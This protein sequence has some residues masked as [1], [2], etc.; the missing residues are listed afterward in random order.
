MHSVS[1]ERP[2]LLD[3]GASGSV[4]LYCAPHVPNEVAE[5]LSRWQADEELLRNAQWIWERHYLVVLRIV[6]IGDAPPLTDDET[7]RVGGLAAE[8]PDDVSTAIL[9]LLLNA[10]VLSEDRAVLRAVYGDTAD[11]EERAQWLR[12][13]LAGRALGE[14]DFIVGGGVTLANALTSVTVISVSE[15]VKAL[16][17]MP[18][19]GL[20]AAALAFGFAVARSKESISNRLQILGQAIVRIA[21]E[22]QPVLQ[23]WQLDRA[24]AA[25]HLLSATPSPAPLTGVQNWHHM[26][27]G[28]LTRACVEVLARVGPMSARQLA[29]RL[30]SLPVAQG[31]AK[32]RAS[33]RN[34]SYFH[35]LPRGRWQLGHPAGVGRDSRGG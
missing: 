2:H 18:P 7:R 35:P 3:A 10:P 26:N 27:R 9:A 11:L 30:P 12:S 34:E 1:R 31:E 29:E 25:A 4:P 21:D 23:A 16:R 17:R 13:A 5:H 28:V 32:V 14:A 15:T 6:E 24:A 20:A 33:L 22:I 19:A 8:D